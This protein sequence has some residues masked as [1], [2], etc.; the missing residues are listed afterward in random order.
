MLC[1]GFLHEAC[2]DFDSCHITTLLQNKSRRVLDRIFFLSLFICLFFF[3]FFLL[4]LLFFFCGE[5]GY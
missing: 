5:D 2:H 1:F 3:C 4:L